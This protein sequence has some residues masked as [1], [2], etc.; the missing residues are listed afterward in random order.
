[1]RIARIED[2]HADGG[3]RVF[4]FLKLVTDDGLVGWSEFSET[5][6]SR[7]LTDVVRKLAALVIGRDPRDVARL[8]SELRAQ[9]RMAPGGLADQA[10]AAIEN[11][12]L[13]VKARALGVPV[14]DML[15][16]AYRDRIALYWSHCGSFRARSPEF[17]EKV[18]GTPPLRGLDDFKRLGE[19]ARARGYRAVKTNPID[20]SGAMPR[21]LNSGFAPQGL[22]FAHNYDA[23]LVSLI[24]DQLAAFRDGLGPQVGL[25]MDLNFSLRPE[26]FIRVA[27]TVEQF[28][29]TWLE[30][31][32]HEPQ[33]LASVR[34]ATKT[35]IASLETIYGRRAY[36]AFFDAY[37]ADVAVVDVVWNGLLES[38]RIANMAEAYEVNVAPHNFY[39]HI[40]SMISAHFC[41]CVPNLRIM[42]YEGDDVPWKDSLVTVPPVVQDGMLLLPTGPG[43]GTEVNEAAVREHP[44]R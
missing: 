43:W 31:D 10:I 11:A 24:T 42:E 35:P 1:M 18:L 3:W 22:D 20:I 41:A 33:A 2:L 32:I 6:W 26:G 14:Y 37:A 38:V 27:Q 25:M 5:S 19:E 16:G 40:A 17:F 30:I 15:G 8:S 23:R 28:G 44:P 34:R 39:G 13:D 12:C 21:M 36:R 9:T 7:G 4:S 29:L